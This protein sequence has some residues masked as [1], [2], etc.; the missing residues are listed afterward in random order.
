L[1][2]KLYPNSHVNEDGTAKFAPYGLRKVETVLEEEFGEKNIATVHP[3]NLHKFIGPKTKVVGISTMD[4]LGL[5]FVSRTYTSILGLNGKP[6]NLAEF[7]DLL[8]NS[9]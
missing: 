8:S 1:R 6:T 9:T 2:K 4:P 3:K 5:G 7:Q